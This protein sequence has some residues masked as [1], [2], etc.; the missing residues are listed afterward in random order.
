MNYFK[1]MLA[2][3]TNRALWAVAVDP[4]TVANLDTSTRGNVPSSNGG[5][6]SGVALARRKAKKL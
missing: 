4:T 3:I 1:K 2:N 6:K 5:T